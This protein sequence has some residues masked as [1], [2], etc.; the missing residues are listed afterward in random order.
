MFYDNSWEEAMNNAEIRE[1]CF[2]IT[3]CITKWFT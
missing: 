1:N 2:S 3:G